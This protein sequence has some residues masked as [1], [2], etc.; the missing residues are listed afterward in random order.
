MSTI[1]NNHMIY[2]LSRVSNRLL[3]LKWN[4]QQKKTKMKK[5]KSMKA[6]KPPFTSMKAI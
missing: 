5:K 6:E 1:A 4:D 2:T 3:S